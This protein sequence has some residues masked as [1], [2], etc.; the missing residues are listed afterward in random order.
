MELLFDQILPESDRLLAL[1]MH[2]RKK[3]LVKLTQCIGFDPIMLPS[4][5]QYT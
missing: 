5:S 2:A 4:I 1:L 3:D